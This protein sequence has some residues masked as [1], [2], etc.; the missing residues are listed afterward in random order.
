MTLEEAKKRIIEI[1]PAAR[2]AFDSAKISLLPEK[3]IEK[4]AA[5]SPCK[6][7]ISF[8]PKGTIIYIAQEIQKDENLFLHT[9]AHEILHILLNHQHFMRRWIGI[10]TTVLNVCADI[11]VEELLQKSNLSDK[12]IRETICTS[13]KYNLP[14]GG[15]ATTYLD[16]FYQRLNQGLN[17]KGQTE[18]E[19][20]LTMSPLTPELEKETTG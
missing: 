12:R 1:F 20:K 3:E 18:W 7:F 8:S 16:I 5:Y 13:Q 14:P 6:G 10:P 15:D 9:I 4:I 19:E 11:E 17:P 2:E